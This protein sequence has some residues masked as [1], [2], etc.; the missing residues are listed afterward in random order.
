MDK[1]PNHKCITCGTMYRACNAC[2]RA[3][4]WRKVCESIEC[5]QVYLAYLQWRDQ[6]HDAEQ[7]NIRVSEIG[8]DPSRLN[9]ALRKVYDEGI[10]QQTKQ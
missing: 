9:N 4:S 6:T 5:Y 3:R 7:F 8:Y 1:T 10:L 2:E